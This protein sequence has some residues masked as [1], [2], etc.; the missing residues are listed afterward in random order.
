[1]KD[2][3][4]DKA[5]KQLV[6]SVMVLTD[7][8]VLDDIPEVRDLTTKVS[9]VRCC[10]P[11][12]SIVEDEAPET[13]EDILPAVR[14]MAADLFS[15]VYSKLVGTVTV[16]PFRRT[17]FPTLECVALTYNYNNQVITL[18]WRDSYGNML[19]NAG[20]YDNEAVKL[21]Q[22]V[23]STLGI[24]PLPAYLMDG[25]PGALELS[26]ISGHGWSTGPVR[27]TPYAIGLKTAY[28]TAMARYFPMMLIT[29]RDCTYYVETEPHDLKYG[30]LKQNVV[31]M[32]P[33]TRIMNQA[34]ARFRATMPDD[35]PFVELPRGY[36]AV[37]VPF[38]ILAA[39]LT[40]TCQHQGNYRD[41]LVQQLAV[42]TA[43]AS[44]TNAADE[45]YRLS[46]HIAS[47]YAAYG[48]DKDNSA[49]QKLIDAAKWERYDIL[50]HIGA[51]PSTYARL[52]TL[53]AKVYQDAS[54]P[55][56][57]I[58]D[59]ITAELA[60]VYQ[61]LNKRVPA[62]PEGNDLVARGRLH[63][64]RDI[65]A[66]YVLQ[67]DECYYAIGSVRTADNLGI[68]VYLP[69]WHKIVAPTTLQHAEWS[70]KVEEIDA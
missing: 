38:D 27:N 4:V 25:T 22:K 68:G 36:R 11:K 60:S 7:A 14:D 40:G 17:Y 59:M 50:L 53:E 28:S 57:T 3:K 48:S 69:T 29:S 63:S 43:H 64:G 10:G 23:A 5:I 30:V 35:K 66:D 8:G 62:L 58:A 2:K 33:D 34:R 47:L 6:D 46:R 52:A 32:H 49:Y 13:V 16:G 67:L 56:R 55:E 51:Q 9:G 31:K 54:L 15:Q 41:R 39:R 19:Y 61:E 42:L 44:Y 1:M 26:F 45:I 37:P 12:P 65:R 24:A 18:G 21:V 70:N 20:S